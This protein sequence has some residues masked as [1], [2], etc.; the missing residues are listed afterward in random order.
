MV[1]NLV[2]LK[3]PLKEEEIKKLKIGDTVELSGTIY[4]ARDMAHKF[5]VEKKPK[6]F[7]KL[8]ENSVL[9]HCGPI[10]RK[11]GGKWQVIAA[12]PT[13]SIRE[14]P[15]EADVI[16]GYRIRAVI[17]KGGMGKKTQ[18]ALKKYGGVYLSAVGGAAVLLAKSIIKV[19]NVYKLEFGLPEAFWE[20]E[21]KNMPLIVTMDGHGNS[22]HYDIEKTS[23][24][25]LKK[26]I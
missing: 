22:M 8:L 23:K 15:Y 6:L 19:S 2:K 21:V 12:G 7:K 17:G 26:L 10:V 9:Y 5:L 14:E 16:K 20:L 3:T 13:T 25:Q 4:T 1:L 24:R 18:K 11:K